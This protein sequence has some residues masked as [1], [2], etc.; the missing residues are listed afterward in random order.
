MRG[1]PRSEISHNKLQPP[2]SA[3]SY[4]K[5]PSTKKSKVDHQKSFNSAKTNPQLFDDIMV[6][7][8]ES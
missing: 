2:G 7:S 4:Q 6:C 3:K 8:E 1:P 5:K